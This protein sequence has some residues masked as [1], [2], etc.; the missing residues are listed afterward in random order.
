MAYIYIYITFYYIP[1]CIAKD[2]YLGM[3]YNLERR[4]YIYVIV[5]LVNQEF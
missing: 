4:Y 5:V 1:R 2:M 3:I